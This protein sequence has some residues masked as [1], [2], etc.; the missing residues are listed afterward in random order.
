MLTAEEIKAQ[1]TGHR[2]VGGGGGGGPRRRQGP[3]SGASVPGAGGMLGK[4]KSQEAAMETSRLFSE[5]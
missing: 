2:K 3:H 4:H 5:A 1:E